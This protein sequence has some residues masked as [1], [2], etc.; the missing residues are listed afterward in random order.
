M[1][2]SKAEEAI[3]ERGRRDNMRNMDHDVMTQERENDKPLTLVPDTNVL[4][5]GRAL[6]ELPW[7]ELGRDEID[8][9][10][11]APV[12]RE[13]DKLKNQSGRQSK[14]ARALSSRIRALLKAPTGRE[15]LNGGEPAVTL[16]VDVRTFREMA[17][18]T[19][20]LGH[21]DQ[22]LISHALHLKDEGADVLLL[23]DDTI[24]HTTAEGVGLASRLLEDGWRREP[25]PDPSEKEIRR[26]S[27]ENARL[28]EAE[29]RIEL[30]FEDMEGEKIERLEAEITRWTPIPEEEIDSLIALA[31][32]LAPRATEFGDAKPRAT[33]AV[34]EALD[35]IRPAGLRAFY[36]GTT[37]EPATEEEIEEYR[38][39][40]YPKWL[41]EVREALSSL[42]E[43]LQRSEAL[44]QFVAKASN[45]GARPAQDALLTLQANGA[46]GLFDVEGNSRDD[47]DD[48]VTSSIVRLPQPP[49][50]PKGRRRRLAS[51]D[52]LGRFGRELV[53]PARIQQHLIDLPSLSA[54][55]PRKQDAFYW[56]EGRT[57]W[58]ERIE[59]ECGMWRH[60]GNGTDITVRVHPDGLE[61]RKGLIELSAEA[62]NLSNEARATLPI[63]VKVRDKDA[64]AEG[65]KL[66]RALRMPMP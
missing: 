62:A 48:D 9:L 1:H 34:E 23:T 44:P 27:E 17:N 37:Y 10:V 31:E 22:A 29:P 20:D 43:K 50:P 57:G 60:G 65:Q 46:L 32:E 66:V 28:R 6:A 59:L 40:R 58:C 24:C 26:L 4:I 64:S 41:D 13:L 5:H 18:E 54:P 19:L 21:A 7:E 47:E 30:W 49:K 38:S 45:D 16:K 56:R 55:R 51:H 25:E 3:V 36:G 52:L 39:E 42:H 63:V 11:I 14:I 2:G 33:D 15:I 8:V 35:K 53:E 61:D 12:I